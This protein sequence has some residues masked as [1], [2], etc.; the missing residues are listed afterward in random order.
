MRKFGLTLLFF[1]FSLFL[2]ACND[3]DVTSDGLT[4]EDILNESIS[5]ME[6]LSSYSMNLNSEQS[7]GDGEEDVTISIASDMDLVL[8][9]LTFFQTINMDMGMM[10]LDMTYESYFSEEHG[11]FMEEPFSGQWL[12]L[13]AEFSDEFMELSDMQI[14]PQE[15]LE[16]F[17]D[18]ISELTL[19]T[20]DDH[21]VIK[22]VGEGA[23]FQSLLDQLDGLFGEG[24]DGIDEMLQ[25]SLPEMD[26]KNIE[27]E[28]II[29]KETFYQKEASINLELSME[30]MGETISVEQ[31]SHILMSKY[32]ELN[33]FTIP[34]EVLNNS[35]EMNDDALFGEFDF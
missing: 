24:L 15:Q 11:F 30:F 29:D 22:L 12:K 25:S 4:V 34:E 6:G 2:I 19:T 32:N 9:P 17:K 5:A 28:I 35:I 13:P 14:S 26:I 3:S 7:I 31:Q 21:Y 16:P 18:Y 1:A 8:D 27:Y 20:E 10:G 33:D 23:D